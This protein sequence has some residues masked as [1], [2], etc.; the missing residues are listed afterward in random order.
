DLSIWIRGPD[1]LDRLDAVPAR[2]HSH[3]DEY[4]RIRP[5][6]LDGAFHEF[7][8]VLALIRGIEL[9]AGAATHVGRLAEQ[10][11]RGPV[12]LVSGFAAGA[13]AENFAEILMNRPGIIDD[14]DAKILFGER[15]FHA[16]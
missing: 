8:A 3:V 5:A 10:I 13:A 15:G 4:H 6:G 2:R 16:G 14:E 1:V 7:E 12:E 9:E 11:G